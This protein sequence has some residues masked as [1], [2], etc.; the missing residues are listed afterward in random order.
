MRD[1]I[2]LI[3]KLNIKQAGETAN[4]PDEK[5]ML[6]HGANTTTGVTVSSDHLKAVLGKAGIDCVIMHY[7]DDNGLLEAVRGNDAKLYILQVT[8][9]ADD[10]L[11]SMLKL[12]KNIVLGIHSTICNL[13]VEDDALRRLIR[14]SQL[15]EPHFAISCPSKVE[16][17]GFN[18]FSKTPFIYLPNTYAFPITAPPKIRKLNQKKIKISLF[19][20]LRSLKN[21]MAQVVAVSLLAKQGFKIELHLIDDRSHLAASIKDMADSLPYKVIFHEMADNKAI[22]RLMSRMDL[23]LQVSLSETF[24]Y[25]AFEQMALSVPV[26]ASTAV[27]YATQIAKFNS[28][29]SMANKMRKIIKNEKTYQKYCKLTLSRAMIVQKQINTSAVSA[30]KTAIQRGL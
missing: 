13:Q 5:A 1:V 9:F 2:I 7:A 25:A 11:F 16:V 6:Y 30:I 23:G 19:C 24:S 3:K 26:V 18:S 17:D 14:F 12:G 15:R 10:T 4:S 29:R 20:A 27:P 22:L 21:V 8:T 28:A